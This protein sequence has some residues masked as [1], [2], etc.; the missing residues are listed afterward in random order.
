M[1]PT[2]VPSGAD[3]TQVGPMLSPLTL[4]S[5]WL[6]WPALSGRSWS[7]LGYKWKLL[8]HMFNTYKSFNVMLSQFTCIIISNH[9]TWHFHKCGQKV[10]SWIMP[11]T[12]KYLANFDGFFSKPL[13]CLNLN[14][15]SENIVMISCEDIGSFIERYIITTYNL[16]LYFLLFDMGYANQDLLTVIARVF[17]QQVML[18]TDALIVVRSAFF[19]SNSIDINILRP[20]QM[21]AICT[22]K[23]LECF[24]MTI[25]M[26]CSR[27]VVV[28]SILVLRLFWVS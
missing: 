27:F 14:D 28:Q 18:I 19:C 26:F 23:L 21:A 10:M 16:K 15:K 4:L 1:G 17:A 9:I 13:T 6:A 20:R 11:I 8:Y 22:H 24:C 2:W 3:R 12:L 7:N 5:G 25:V